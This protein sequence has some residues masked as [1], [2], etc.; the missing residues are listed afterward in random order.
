M[1]WLLIIVIVGQPPI[2]S[3]VANLDMCQ[4]VIDAERADLG[5]DVRSARCMPIG[6][7]K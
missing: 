1:M 2:F 7:V 3:H 4:A 5:D 6:I